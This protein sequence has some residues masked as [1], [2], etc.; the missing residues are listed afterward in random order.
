MRQLTLVLCACL[1]AASAAVA[2]APVTNVSVTL[3]PP[4]DGKQIV[5]IRLTPTATFTADRVDAVCQYRQEFDWPPKALHP[6]RRILE[7]AIFTYTARTIKFVDALDL[8]LNFFVPVSLPEL[9][10]KHGA[11]TFAPNAP[12]TLSRVTVTA[13]TNDQLIW[14]FQRTPLTNVADGVLH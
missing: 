13:Y 7:P 1:A 12:V 6:G 10:E 9:R 2:Q 4:A 5:S 8:N 3:D 11:T 14:T